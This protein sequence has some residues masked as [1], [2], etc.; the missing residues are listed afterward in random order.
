MWIVARVAKP[1][2]A[3]PMAVPIIQVKVR[4]SPCLRLLQ[5]P[6]PRLRALPQSPL[7]RPCLLL[8]PPYLRQ[9][10]MQWPRG[11]SIIIVPA[12]SSK[13]TSQGPFGSTRRMG[14]RR[15]ILFLDVN[16][17]VNYFWTSKFN[18]SFVCIDVILCNINAF[19]F[20]P[21]N[22]GNY[23]LRKSRYFTDVTKFSLEITDYGNQGTSPTSRNVKLGYRRG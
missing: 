3:I 13:C 22:S 17:N 20:F 19:V 11:I 10:S 9:S 12:Q 14:E 16:I 18:F 21:G 15:E 4:R 7:L 6:L 8:S 5:A 2:V 23:R 1:I